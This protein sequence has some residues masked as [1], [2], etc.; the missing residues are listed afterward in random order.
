M[1]T[2]YLRLDV[3]PNRLHEVCMINALEMK[4]GDYVEF[5]FNNMST[6]K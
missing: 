4:I 6:Q 1:K 5:K 2:K 3:G